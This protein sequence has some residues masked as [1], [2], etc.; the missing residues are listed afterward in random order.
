MN[1]YRVEIREQSSKFWAVFFYMKRKVSAVT[2]ENTRVLGKMQCLADFL[3]VMVIVCA[4][5]K[6]AKEDMEAVKVFNQS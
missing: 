2:P 1:S 6:G 5:V 3:Q 4:N